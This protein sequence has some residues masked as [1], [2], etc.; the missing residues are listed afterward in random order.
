MK[1]P[2]SLSVKTTQADTVYWTCVCVDWL[3]L[4]LVL[5]YRVA[6]VDFNELIS[7]NQGGMILLWTC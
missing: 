3:V 7:M 6:R 4:C 1:C 2:M 5:H